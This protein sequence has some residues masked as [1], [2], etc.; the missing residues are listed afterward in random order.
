M[1][2]MIMDGKI[3]ITHVLA[4]DGKNVQWETKLI[5]I[6]FFY[7]IISTPLQ[8]YIISKKIIEEKI[9]WLIVDFI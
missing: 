9:E 5:I 7:Y 2:V 8:Y 4:V 6:I 1:I 3:M